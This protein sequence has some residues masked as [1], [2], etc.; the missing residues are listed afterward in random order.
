MTIDLIV[1]GLMGIGAGWGFAGAL[2]SEK[3]FDKIGLNIMGVY[4][5][6]VMTAYTAFVS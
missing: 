1:V 6:L 3:R 4:N 2:S 5:L